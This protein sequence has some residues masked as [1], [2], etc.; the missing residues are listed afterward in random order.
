[1]R[2]P[3]RALD[4]HSCRYFH[5]P[6]A[7][8]VMHVSGSEKETCLWLPEAMPLGRCIWKYP[9]RH[10]GQEGPKVLRAFI[11]GTAVFSLMNTAHTMVHHFLRLLPQWRNVP[12]EGAISECLHH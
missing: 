9:R 12:G 10:S 4:L 11:Q 6:S 5:S 7:M 1:M 3:G 8:R 2:Y